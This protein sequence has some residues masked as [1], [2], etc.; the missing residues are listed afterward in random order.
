[1]DYRRTGIP[2]HAPTPLYPC[3]YRAA[4]ASLSPPSEWAPVAQSTPSPPRSAL[5][6]P[7]SPLHCLI[8]NHH[9]AVEYPFSPPPLSFPPS[10]PSFLFAFDSCRPWFSTT[11]IQWYASFQSR[12]SCIST[13][14]PSIRPINHPACSF[15]RPP[16]HPGRRSLVISPT[17]HSFYSNSVLSLFLS[18]P[19]FVH[20]RYTI[21]CVFQ[22]DTRLAR[23]CLCLA[24]IHGI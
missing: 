24:L 17:S 9:G 2:F 7:P 8:I 13:V 23:D 19:F 15:H 20:L 4:Q 14:R 10:F 6:S 18:T 16:F 21:I 11:I 12:G 5:F 3:D 22:D 1:M